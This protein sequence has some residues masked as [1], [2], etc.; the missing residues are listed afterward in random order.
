M[1]FLMQFYIVCGSLIID[2]LHCLYGSTYQCVHP[3]IEDNLLLRRQGERKVLPRFEVLKR[4]SIAL[5]DVGLRI[6][7]LVFK[8]FEPNE[9]YFFMFPSVAGT[10]AFSCL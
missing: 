3:T 10:N 5:I 2:C 4:F 7:E 9:C 1:W 6:A 8:R